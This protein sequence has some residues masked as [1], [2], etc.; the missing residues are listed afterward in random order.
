MSPGELVGFIGGVLLILGVIWRLIRAIY[1]LTR[2][3]ETAL[4]R[5]TNVEAQLNTNGGN[6]ARDVLDKIHTVAL[7][8]RE[9]N[10]RVEAEQRRAAGLAG[11]AAALAGTADQ[12]IRELGD[13]AT[14]RHH[15]NSRRLDRLEGAAREERIRREFYLAT[16]RELYGIELLDPDD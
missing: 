16:L 13:L 3:G 15:D 14:A 12:R 4:E 10:E 7:E 2:V 9:A 8:N 5:L 1:R 11:K 6:S